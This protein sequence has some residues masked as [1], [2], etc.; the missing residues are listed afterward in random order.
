MST[1]EVTLQR[2]KNVRKHPNADRLALA[3]VL[4]WTVVTQPGIQDGDLVLYFPI[5]AVLPPEVERM[6][7]GPQ[8]K[9]KLDKG[10]IKTIQLRGEYSQ[11]LL[12]PWSEAQHWPWLHPPT[13]PPGITATLTEGADVT[14]A[15]GV[16]KYVLPREARLQIHREALKA[17]GLARWGKVQDREDKRAQLSTREIPR[18]TDLEHLAKFPDSFK[19]GEQVVI[20]EK[21][22][23]TS[24]RYGH[25]RPAPTTRWQRFKA[26]FGIKPKYHFVYGS[27]N[28]EYVGDPSGSAATP[29]APADT[30]FRQS[31]N[32]GKIYGELA[33]RLGLYLDGKD[34]RLQRNEV[35]YG[36]I[37]GANIQKN[38]AYGAPGRTGFHK[39][40]YVYDVR[41]EAKGPGGT[42]GRY[43]DHE[44]LVV[45][46]AMRKLEMVPVL[47]VGPYY[48]ELVERLAKGPSALDKRSTPIREGVVVRKLKGEAEG[49]RVVRKVVS[50]EFLMR[51]QADGGTEDDELLDAVDPD[52]VTEPVKANEDGGAA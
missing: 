1:V 13:M 15:L 39:D 23:G 40:F 35:V 32:A 11:G 22:H 48:P 20:T 19:A 17:A 38:Y 43:L 28:V 24:A 44:D 27:R 4:G 12:V 46:C 30:Q 21:L 9:I 41:V 51:N 42:G 37:V 2:V 52:A 31:P 3:D 5:D 14:Q 49:N 25:V 16:T 29:D 26:F 33:V 50:K 8:S 10:R 6:I 18:Y 45:W 36:E 7:F 34:S 47:Y